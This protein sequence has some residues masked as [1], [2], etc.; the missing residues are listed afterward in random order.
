MKY[1][2]IVIGSG[3]AGYYFAI[4]G[5]KKG[6]KIAIIEKDKLGGTAF[7]T[8]CLP[9]KKYL[10][11][12][13]NYKRI[14]ADA[15]LIDL[16]LNI[17]N[18][19]LFLIGKEKVNN[20]ENHLIQKLSKT[21][22]D[23]INGEGIIIDDNKV[24]VE[25]E[26]YTGDKI[27]IATGTRPT[28]IGDWPEIDEKMI[29]SHKGLIELESIPKEL[30]ILGGNVEGIEFAS[31]FSELGTKITIIEQENCILQGN[32]RDLVEPIKNQLIKN[33][34]KFLLGK[35]LNTIIKS[36][37]S[38]ILDLSEDIKLKTDALL[39]T[40][41][42]KSNIPKTEKIDLTIE[43]SYIKVD[44]NL[45]TSAENIYAIGDINGLHGMAHIAIQQGIFLADYLWEN[46][47]I[48]YKY[49]SLPRCIFTINELAGAGWQEDGN[50]NIEVVK[51]SLK[52][53]IRGT[54]LNSNSFLKLIVKD[55]IVKG[56]WINDL[57]AGEIMGQIGL[58]IDKELTIDEF[59]KALW[60][61]PTITEVFLEGVLY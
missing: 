22:I 56:A 11:S 49:D 30:V 35:K 7:A 51:V 9:V 25:G 38:L 12:I 47:S 3:A 23:I 44:S 32:D 21:S 24:E 10:E 57:N 8:G 19:K 61:H 60:I 2:A 36:D 16:E 45:M 15:D 39:I 59:K 29:F 34:V 33:N 53:T 52:E 27:I 41:I 1:D 54:N 17:T 26:I 18:E 4:A 31:L 40:G 50:E 48:T 55:N 6:K 58:W 5:E 13:K 43:N 37:D 42:R 46:K 14:K 28:Q 20:I